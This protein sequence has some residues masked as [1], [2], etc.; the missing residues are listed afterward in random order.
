MGTHLSFIFRGY[1]TH[2]LE[3]KTS[4]FHGHLGSKVCKIDNLLPKKKRDKETTVLDH[5]KS[6][7]CKCWCKM[8]FIFVCVWTSNYCFLDRTL[9]SKPTLW[10]HGTAKNAPFEDVFPT[11]ERAGTFHC[12]VNLLEGEGYLTFDVTFF[13]DTR[14][15][16]QVSRAS[17]VQIVS[18]SQGDFLIHHD[19]IGWIERAVALTLKWWVK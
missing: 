4:I 7:S 2:I 16:L 3:P 14:N 12:H 5:S 8:G 10:Q 18:G 13:H 1:F 11:K 19:R 17:L 6:Q 9:T 15:L